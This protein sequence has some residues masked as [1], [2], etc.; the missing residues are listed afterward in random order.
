[1]IGR[2]GGRSRIRVSGA[3]D[4]PRRPSITVRY[5]PRTYHFYPHPKKNSFGI[6]EIFECHEDNFIQEKMSPS[7]IPFLYRKKR[8]FG[9]RLTLS[10]ENPVDVNLI[11]NSSY[12][13]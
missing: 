10:A 8:A 11:V 13:I 3:R 2:R 12:I 4:Q 5:G 9:V 6:L 1:M 7:Q